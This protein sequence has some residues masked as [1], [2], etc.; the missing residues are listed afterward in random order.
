M[1][2]EPKIN[3]EIAGD[4]SGAK[5]AFSDTTTSAQKMATD[6]TR[7]GGETAKQMETTSK[8]F[9]SSVK[10]V[11]TDMTLVA[12]LAVGVY[13]NFDRIEDSARRVDKAH[14]GLSKAIEE[15]DKKQKLANDALNK[16]GE[17]SQS[18]Y[19]PRWT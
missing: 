11:G 5:K 14:L 16:F 15:V 8:S 4:S 13:N 6:V 9:S 7:S 17:K 10:S 19:R 3:I 18:I 1:S 2:M 12:G